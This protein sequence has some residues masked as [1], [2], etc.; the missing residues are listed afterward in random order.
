LAF[1]VRQTDCNSA[2]CFTT[3]KRF[4]DSNN[5]C[6]LDKYNIDNIIKDTGDL[7]FVAYFC[8]FIYQ[9][10]YNLNDKWGFKSMVHHG[11]S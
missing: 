3:A 8:E 5:A 4:S 7:N 9:N 2:I 6:L 11:G 1:S 10:K